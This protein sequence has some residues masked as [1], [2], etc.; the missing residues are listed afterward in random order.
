MQ[1]CP[2]CTA[3]PYAAVG[4]GALLSGSTFVYPVAVGWLLVP[5]AL[6][7]QAAA[8]PVWLVLSLAAITA[9][10]WLLGLRSLRAVALVL[11]ASCALTGL[12][13]G[14]LNPLLFVGLA[15]CSR[16]RAQPG[17][18][19]AWQRCWW[20]PSCSCFRCWCGCCSP[21]AAPGWSRRGGVTA[22]VLA[23]GWLLGP[24][25]PAGY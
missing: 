5:L 21:G 4:G 2:C 24:L 16:L 14:S 23:A 12:Q 3:G 19:Q 13:V 7:G 18:R 9:G 10:C 11:L 6:L 15:L 8:Q 25:G 20:S 17:G 1:R 22:G